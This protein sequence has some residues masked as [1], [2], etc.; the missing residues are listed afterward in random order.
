MN[1][2][3]HSLVLSITPKGIV[4]PNVVRHLVR[5]DSF[6]HKRPHLMACLIVR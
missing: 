6:T 3:S 1:G 2:F 5:V 4:I